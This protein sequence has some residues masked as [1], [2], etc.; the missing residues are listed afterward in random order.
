MMIPVYSLYAFCEGEW[1]FV[2]SRA[3][4]MMVMTMASHDCACIITPELFCTSTEKR[5]TV[6]GTPLPAVPTHGLMRERINPGPWAIDEEDRWFAL[7]WFYVTDVV[8]LVTGALRYKSLTEKPEDWRA[9]HPTHDIHILWAPKED[10]LG[11][12]EDGPASGSESASESG[13]EGEVEG[14]GWGG[15]EH[16]GEEDSTSSNGDA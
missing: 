15:E 12:T 8:R 14:E 11:A 5:L 4:L 10:G 6:R 1:V 9:G 13:S 3:D 2:A 7:H 16:G